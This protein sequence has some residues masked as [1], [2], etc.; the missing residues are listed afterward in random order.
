MV[1]VHSS[2][3]KLRHQLNISHLQTG[4]AFRGQREMSALSLIQKDSLDL[5]VLASFLLFIFF[6]VFIHTVEHFYP[7]LEPWLHWVPLIAQN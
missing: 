7:L 6:I 4:W 5:T 3:P 2:K 1:S